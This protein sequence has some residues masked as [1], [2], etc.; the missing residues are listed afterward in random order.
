MMQLSSHVF[1]QSPVKKAQ[2]TPGVKFCIAT[3]QPATAFL[4]AIGL[5]KMVTNF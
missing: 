4:K 5:M 3:A 2:L 1:E